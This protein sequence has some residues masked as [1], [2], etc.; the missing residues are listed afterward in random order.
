M[1]KRE[2]LACTVDF[3]GSDSLLTEADYET[4]RANT[5]IDKEYASTPHATNA[6]TNQ[7]RA[8]VT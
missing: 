7:C 5:L 3:A 6:A 1:G 4:V 8:A 2:L